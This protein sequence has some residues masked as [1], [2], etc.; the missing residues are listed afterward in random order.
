MSSEVK[1]TTQFN[2]IYLKC[3]IDAAI[4]R[5]ATMIDRITNSSVETALVDFDDVPSVITH[6]QLLFKLKFDTTLE[7]SL[8]EVIVGH[9]MTA[10]R[11]CPG[12]FVIVLRQVCNALRANFTIDENSSL[13][14][15]RAT[16][17]DVNHLVVDPVKQIDRDVGSMLCTAIELAG[18]GGKIM[19]EKTESTIPSVELVRGYTFFVNP[20]W[21]MT[22]RFDDV[23]TF[24]ID[25][26]I[27][28][29]SEIHHL[30][31][32]ISEARETCVLF[33]RGMSADVLHTLRV[34]FDRG[35]A[36]L[37]PIIVNFD[38]EGINTI[39]DVAIVTGCDLVSTHKGDL[40][41]SIKF[42]R[43]PRVSKIFVYPTKIVVQNASS[44]T[45]V[46]AQ[47]MMLMKKRGDINTI[48]DISQLY[49]KRI[50]S[51]SPSQVIIRIPNDKNYVRN[52]QAFDSAL[53]MLTTIV[54]RGVSEVNGTLY[55][56]TM[57]L[58]TNLHVRHCVE[59]LK[60]LGA[61]VIS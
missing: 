10:E 15:R 37:I 2:H 44:A 32:A 45:A 39:N 20:G 6:I 25:G 28:S 38:I 13:L 5:I 18:F 24:V 34:N 51:L 16:V 55:A 50:R 22:N 58:T 30:L 42:E 47:I 26:F 41:S 27:E 4:A 12:G 48:E 53:R 17:D 43:A 11:Q 49:D 23:R 56:T 35:T 1:S 3:D 7:R 40:I 31:M 8:F 19:L 57:L 59:T 9:A 54:D 33:A 21:N 46:T 61:C 60:S 36:R 14:S 29:V 52:A